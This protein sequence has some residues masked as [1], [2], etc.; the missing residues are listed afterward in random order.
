[1]DRKTTGYQ[2]VLRAV[3]A[4]WYRLCMVIAGGLTEV[5][6]KWPLKFQ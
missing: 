1:M 2:D 6:R 4:G 3:T 5:K